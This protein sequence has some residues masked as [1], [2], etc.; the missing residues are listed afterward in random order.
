[1]GRAD[2]TNRFGP[3]FCGIEFSV[4]TGHVQVRII[5]MRA[6]SDRLY[7]I[8][9]GELTEESVEFPPVCTENSIPQKMGLNQ[10]V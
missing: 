8:E 3:V 1:M 2:Y 10:L 5:V 4:H 9:M 6:Q 7:L